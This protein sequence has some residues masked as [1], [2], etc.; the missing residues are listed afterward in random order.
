MEISWL[1][2]QR[3]KMDDRGFGV[4]DSRLRRGDT[5]EVNPIR[6]VGSW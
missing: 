5:S 6:P 1:L 3:L 4:V 2:I